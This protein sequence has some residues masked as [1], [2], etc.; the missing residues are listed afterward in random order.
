MLDELILA[1]CT[2]CGKPTFSTYRVWQWLLPN[3]A[4]SHY[5]NFHLGLFAAWI[6]AKLTRSKVSIYSRLA[7][8]RQA[9][10]RRYG[11]SHTIA[12]WDHT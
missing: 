11:N 10:H 4:S 2:E 12:I 3:V 7:A 9:C 8:C 1:A 5:L 6:V